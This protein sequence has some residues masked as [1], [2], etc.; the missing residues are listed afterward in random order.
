MDNAIGYPLD[1]RLS[2]GQWYSAFW[3]TGDMR[4]LQGPKCFCSHKAL[5]LITQKSRCWGVAKEATAGGNSQHF[6][7]PPLVSAWKTSEERVKKFHTQLTK[8]HYPDLGSASDWLRQILHVARPIR[9]T[10]QI[11]HQYGISA[12]ISQTSFCSGNQWWGHKIPAIFSG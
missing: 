9:S 3:T 5:F 12:L 7:T 6:A 4:F 8:R 2:V 10:S 11:C 1:S